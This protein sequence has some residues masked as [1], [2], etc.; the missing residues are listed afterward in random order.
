MS[1]SGAITP[2]DKNQI[3]IDYICPKTASTSIKV[4]PSES[5]T[6]YFELDGVNGIAKCNKVYP[7]SGSSIEVGT[8]GSRTRLVNVADATSYLDAA[9]IDQVQKGLY[10]YALTA[11]TDPNFTVTLS[12]TPSVAY[13]STQGH[14]IRIKMHTTHTTGTAT[15]NING[16]GAVNITKFESTD[17]V[18]IGYLRQNGI[19]DIMVDTSGGTRCMVVRAVYGPT[20]FSSPALSGFGGLTFSGTTFP[21][22]KVQIDG[23]RVRV[24]I[25]CSTTPGGVTDSI[26]YLTG[27]PVNSNATYP[28]PLQGVSVWSGG[29]YVQVLTAHALNNYIEVRMVSS[30]TLGVGTDININSDYLLA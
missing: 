10:N 29:G 17:P 15:L 5:G 21:L 3:A 1:A 19:Y 18:P 4:R 6:D 16:G 26:F 27:L 7:Y 9:T 30:L 23:R 13:G 8:S 20:D 28:S 2:S 12:P 11:G 14:L 22:C 24:N 25:R